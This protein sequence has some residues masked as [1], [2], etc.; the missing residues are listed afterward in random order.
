MLLS[1]IHWVDRRKNYSITG[2]TKRKNGNSQREERGQR[3][4][5]VVRLIK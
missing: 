5:Q 1:I 2:E 4:F 3:V